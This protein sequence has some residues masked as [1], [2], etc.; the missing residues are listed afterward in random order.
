[1]PGE[2]DDLAAQQLPSQSGDG[3]TPSASQPQQGSVSPPVEPQPPSAAAESAEQGTGSPQAGEVPVP[4]VATAS[5][6][7]YAVH[8]AS[9]RRMEQANQEIANLAKH[10]Y[11]GRAARTDL[12]SKGIWFRVLVGSYPNKEAA[13]QAR[14]VILKLPEY[15]FAQVRRV[16]AP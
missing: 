4:E 8:V 14:E 7:V 2:P 11:E 15:A 9:Y 13:E 3:S 6:P 12:G 5:G 16:T 1:M 10:G